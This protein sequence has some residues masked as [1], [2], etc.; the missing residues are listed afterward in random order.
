MEM[1]GEHLRLG[2][3]GKLRELS[4]QLAVRNAYSRRI[5]GM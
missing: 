5:V 2:V 4:G 3:T 1:R